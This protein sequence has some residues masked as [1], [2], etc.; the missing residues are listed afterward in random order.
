MMVVAKRGPHP[1]RF[2]TEFIRGVTGALRSDENFLPI[3]DS[4]R[5]SIG[6][7]GANPVHDYWRRVPF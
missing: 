1:P 4:P 5:K 6:Q 7:G 2:F 3:S